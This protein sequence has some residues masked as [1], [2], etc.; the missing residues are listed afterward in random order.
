MLEMGKRMIYDFFFFIRAEDGMTL[1]ECLQVA[2]HRSLR[3]HFL[4]LYPREILIL[5][6]HINQTVGIVPLGDK[7]ASPFLQV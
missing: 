2:Y 5:D 6:L 7:T 3:H 1:S 4:L